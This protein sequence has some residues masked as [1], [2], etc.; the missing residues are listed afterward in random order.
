FL[1]IPDTSLCCCVTGI[2]LEIVA[3]GELRFPSCLI[4]HIPGVLHLAILQDELPPVP[5]EQL[6]RFPD[7]RVA[8][9]KH[10]IYQEQEQ[11]STTHE[12]PKGPRLDIFISHSP[13]LE[14]SEQCLHGPIL[15]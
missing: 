6:E 4:Y 8:T 13:T 9:A 1:I 2:I 11:K 10:E 3:S 14:Q 12:A 5:T 7:E 15:Q